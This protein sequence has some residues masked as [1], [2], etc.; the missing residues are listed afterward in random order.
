MGKTAISSTDSIML[1]LKRVRDDSDIATL[2]NNPLTPNP[3]HSKRQVEYS[4]DEE[5]KLVRMLRNKPWIS[6]HDCE[7]SSSE[8]DFE[9]EKVFQCSKLCSETYY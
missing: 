7:S 5:K 1:T 2:D 8:D 3:R 6:Y 4:S 9:Y